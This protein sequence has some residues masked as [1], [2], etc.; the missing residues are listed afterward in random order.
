MYVWLTELTVTTTW[1][2]ISDFFF[3]TFNRNWIFDF[4]WNHLPLFQSKFSQ[5]WLAPTLRLMKS[6]YDLKLELIDLVWNMLH[7]IE[8]KRFCLTLNSSIASDHSVH[9]GINPLLFLTKPP[10][11]LQT[12]QAPLFRQFPPL[13]WFLWPPRPSPLKVRFFSEP[14]TYYSFSSLTPILSLKS[15]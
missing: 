8:L 11:N 15:D 13:Y 6:V 4:Q 10:L 14:P 12:V 5:Y 1:L 7:N 3:E 2:P 9:W